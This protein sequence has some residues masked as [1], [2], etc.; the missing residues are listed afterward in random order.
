[1]KDT[2]RAFVLETLT[3]KMNEPVDPAT[4]QDDMSLGP[5]GLNLESLAFVELMANIETEYDVT[6]EDDELEKLGQLTF[7]EFC[8]A[9]A[10]RTSTEVARSE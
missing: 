10:E 5:E 1:M 9:V 4:V 6:F 8:A 7:G 3:E 2:V